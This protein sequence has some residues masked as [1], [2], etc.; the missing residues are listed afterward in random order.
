MAPRT[1]IWHHCTTVTQLMSCLPS[2][3]TIYLFCLPFLPIIFKIQ[4]SARNFNLSRAPGIDS[5]KSTPCENQFRP[6]KIFGLDWRHLFIFSFYVVE[7]VLLKVGGS[8][9]G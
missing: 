5:T 8:K 1:A 7:L 4:L 2:F 6:G 3:Q 9:F